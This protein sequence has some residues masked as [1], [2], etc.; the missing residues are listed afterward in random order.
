MIIRTSARSDVIRE[1]INDQVVGRPSNIRSNLLPLKFA[2]MNLTST[3]NNCITIPLL[4]LNID[5]D[6]QIQD[7]IENEVESPNCYDK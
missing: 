6:H 4:M 2:S 7:K 5:I 3:I 1:Q